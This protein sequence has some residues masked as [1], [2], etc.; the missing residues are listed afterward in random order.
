MG[1]VLA[2]SGAWFRW[3]EWFYGMSLLSLSAVVERC[4]EFLTA[5]FVYTDMLW[6]ILPLILTLLVM[7][8]YFGV[9]SSEELGWSSAG[10]PTAACEYARE[11]LDGQMGQIIPFFRFSAQV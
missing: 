6:I 4:I 11:G 2:L 3:L 10:H 5:P 7:E 1:V 9:Y 8:L